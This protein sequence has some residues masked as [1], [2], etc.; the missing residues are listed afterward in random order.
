MEECAQLERTLYVVCC[1]EE[2]QG[3]INRTFNIFYG[4]RVETLKQYVNI[5]SRLIEL[6]D[7][8]KFHNT[9]TLK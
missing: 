5:K 1:K 4:K 2:G 3:E 7:S 9:N 8:A 6:T